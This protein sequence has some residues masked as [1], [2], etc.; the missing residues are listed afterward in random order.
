M[1]PPKV[2][3]PTGIGINSHFELGQAFKNAGAQVDYCHINDLIAEP[4]LI[5]LYQMLG[6][7]GG[8][9][10][11]DQLGAGQSTRNRIYDSGLKDKLEEKLEDPT[12]PI[13]AVCNS[14]QMLAKLD[15]FPVKL[16]TV[17]NDSGKHETG[18]WDMKVN[19]NNETVWLN[20]LWDYKGPIFAP[21]SHGEGRIIIPE[22]DLQKVKDMNLIALQ[23]IK[24]HM[25]NYLE[26]SR[27][28][29]YNPNGSIAD[30]AG[31]GWNNNL[32]LFPHFERL[33]K[34]AQRDDKALLQTGQIKEKMYSDTPD[35][36]YEPTYL[37]FKAAVDFVKQN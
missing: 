27:G 17:R 31:L 8:F 6:L 28:E 2:I 36:L 34:N 14:L 7:P 26:S 9:M 33:L 11:G 22:E 32:V 4:T 13:Y 18:S 37:M 20:N 35:G 3:I 10:M 25:C 24:G 15:L 21:I 30:I 12:F 16:G 23:Y 29:R 19:E 1:T 5:D